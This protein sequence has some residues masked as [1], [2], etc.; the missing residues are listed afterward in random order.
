MEL[1]L[2][3]WVSIR[4]WEELSGKWHSSPFM[5]LDVANMEEA[6]A[7]FHKSVQRMDRGL[8]PN[9]VRYAALTGPEMLPEL[10]C[11]QLPPASPERS[12]TGSKCCLAHDAN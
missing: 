2:L 10:H 5:Q 3:L 7:R 9:A 11:C 12:E 1:R 6:V 4:E 8:P